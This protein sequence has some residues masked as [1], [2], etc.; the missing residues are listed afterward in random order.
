M[1]GET[2]SKFDEFFESLWVDNEFRDY[3]ADNNIPLEFILA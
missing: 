1:T 2:K 3:V